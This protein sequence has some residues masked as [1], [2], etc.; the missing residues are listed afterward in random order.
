MDTWQG[1]RNK[2]NSPRACNKILIVSR[3][4]PAEIETKRGN[5]FETIFRTGGAVNQTLRFAIKLGGV[6]LNSTLEGVSA[7]REDRKKE[8]W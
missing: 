7:F 4:F 1:S 3:V 6:F 5:R 2:V 8:Q